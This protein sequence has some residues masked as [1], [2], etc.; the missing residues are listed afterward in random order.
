MQLSLYLC[1]LNSLFFFNSIIVINFSYMFFLSWAPLVSHA[2]SFVLPW[3]YSHR[4]SCTTNSFP[5]LENT[6]VS[7]KKCIRPNLSKVSE[8]NSPKIVSLRPEHNLF[9]NV[10][11]RFCLNRGK[12]LKQ[13]EEICETCILT[14]NPQRRAGSLKILCFISLQ[15]RILRKL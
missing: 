4:R 5:L 2:L 3:F 6:R 1:T 8:G 12:S 15:V 11:N 13:C 7:A 9:L 14:K 10:R